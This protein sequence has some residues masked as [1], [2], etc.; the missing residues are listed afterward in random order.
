[1]RNALMV[2]VLGTV[3]VQGSVRAQPVRI[4]AESVVPENPRSIYCRYVNWRPADGE[5]VSLNPPRVS[6][7]YRAD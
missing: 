7:P 2:L 5:T 6:W 3:F 4:G 1:M